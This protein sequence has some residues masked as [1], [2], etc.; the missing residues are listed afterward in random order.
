MSASRAENATST[1]I[2]RWCRSSSA[3]A[4]NAHTCQKMIGSVSR[5]AAQRL[6]QID[7]ENGSSG[8]NVYGFLRFA[9]RGRFSQSST[10]P[11]KA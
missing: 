7:V 11:W 3:G 10:A 9:G 4:K 6:I 1:A 8:L 2:D 5:N